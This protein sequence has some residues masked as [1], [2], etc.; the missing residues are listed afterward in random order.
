MRD[1]STYSSIV[2]PQT[3]TN[4]VAPRRAQ[5]RQALAHEAVD[6]NPLQ[7]DGVQHAGGRLDDARGRMAFALGEEQPLD[8]D[9]AERGQIDDAARIRRRIRSSRWRRSAG[10]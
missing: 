1:T 5:L 10:S 7:A 4:T 8:G 9:A 6:A 3:L 2:V